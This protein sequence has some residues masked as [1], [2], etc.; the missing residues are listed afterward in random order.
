MF[1][2]LPLPAVAIKFETG[3]TSGRG[4]KCNSKTESM[5]DCA[6]N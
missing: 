1:I 5:A 3:C 2:P 4:K 6:A